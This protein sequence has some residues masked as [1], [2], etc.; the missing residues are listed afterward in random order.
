MGDELPIALWVYITTPWEATGENPF[1]L[2]YNVDAIIPFESGL[3]PSESL[4]DSPLEDGLDSLEER[5]ET[6]SIQTLSTKADSLEG[7]GG[8]SEELQSGGLHSQKDIRG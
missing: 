1:A 6:S 3:L 4:A 5:R 2:T 8:M 7:Q